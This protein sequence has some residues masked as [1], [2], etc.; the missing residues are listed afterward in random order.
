MSQ[1]ISRFWRLNTPA[2]AKGRAY[3][4]EKLVTGQIDCPVDPEQHNLLIMSGELSVLLTSKRMTDFVWT[5][6]HELL[7]Q[8]RVLTMF[9][10]QG[11]TGFD[12]RPAK[13]RM[14]VRA[15]EPDP[16]DDAPGVSARAAARV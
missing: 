10:E 15:K 8:D 7:I 16:C 4:D 12:V 13:A 5:W 14:K 9:R 6:L 1:A 2:T 11:F 3:Q